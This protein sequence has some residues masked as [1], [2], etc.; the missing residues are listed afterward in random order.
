MT[1]HRIRALVPANLMSDHS[2][3]D[4]HFMV[5]KRTTKLPRDDGWYQDMQGIYNQGLFVDLNNGERG[6]AAFTRGLPEYEIVDNFNPTN[7]E[8]NKTQSIAITLVRAVE[9]LSQKGHLGRKSGL[10]G[11]NLKTPVLN[12]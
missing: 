3:A 5:M 11:P 1:G 10:N 7:D 6:I 2:F 4:D 8:S 12:V 9:W